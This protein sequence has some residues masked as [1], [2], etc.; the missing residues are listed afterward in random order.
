MSGGSGVQSPVWPSF[1]FNNSFCLGSY[2][3]T[4]NTQ[5]LWVLMQLIQIGKR[6]GL[7]RKV[8][9]SSAHMYEP[10]LLLVHCV[11]ISLI[12]QIKY[13]MHMTFCQRKTL[14]SN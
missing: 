10:T 7:G 4:V 12:E 3:V 11:L 2:S 6:F 9:C 1:L 14:L 5:I 8:D 13:I